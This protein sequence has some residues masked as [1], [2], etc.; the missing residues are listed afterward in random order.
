MHTLLLTLPLM[1]TAP[2]FAQDDWTGRTVITTK[3]NVK[4]GHT[5]PTVSRSTRPN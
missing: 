2:A 4:I 1:M 5:D 3:D